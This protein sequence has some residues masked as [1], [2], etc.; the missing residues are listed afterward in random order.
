[1]TTD[2][3]IGRIE[4][5]SSKG[6]LA[7]L[8][9]W[10][11]VLH[12][13]MEV[14]GRPVGSA[15]T[16]RLVNALSAAKLLASGGGNGGV[17]QLTAAVKAAARAEPVDAA[18]L[19]QSWASLS[20]LLADPMISIEETEL[21]DV[22]KA[23]K[24]AKEFERLAE[25]GERAIV[26]E[27]EDAAIRLLY[28]QALIN[29]GKVHAGLEMLRTVFSLKGLRQAEIDEA[30][31][32]MGRG[33]KQIYV[34]NVR[35]AGTSRA[36]RDRFKRELAQSIRHYE[37]AYRPDK[38][39]TNYWHGINLVS[40]M[41]LARRDGHDDLA[42]LDGMNPEAL[43]QRLV[44]ALEPQAEVGEH[45]LLATLGEASIALGDYVKAKEWYSRF[46]HHPDITQF[47][48]ASASRQLEQVWRLSPS[49]GGAGPLFAVLKAAE[50][51]SPNGRFEL[52][53]DG[54]KAIQKFAA[55][56]EAR[57]FRES[58]VAGGKFVKLAELQIVVKRAAAVVAIQGSYGGTIGTGFIVEGRSLDPALGSDWF[59]VTNAHV[60][61]GEKS[62]TTLLPSEARLIL[63]GANQVEL[64]CE[65][66]LLFESPPD[67]Y[68][69]AIVRIT[70]G[71]SGVCEP[72]AVADPNLPIKPAMAQDGSDG[73]PVSVIGYPLGG[74]L[75][76]SRVVGANGWIV[77]RGPRTKTSADPVYMH[78]IAPTEPGNSG[79]PIFETGSWQVIGLHHAGFD[80]YE[81][82]PRLN[83]A[84][85]NSF[86]NEG[87]CIQSIRA[88]LK[89]NSGGGP[90]KRGL[91]SL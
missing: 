3:I 17:Y 80:K 90:R 10:M 47:C 67:A 85:G 75:S 70:G 13:K 34:D 65:G 42:T 81:G 53:A 36:L 29:S 18:G 79:S 40:L 77:D 55:T 1:M 76:L 82:R 84:S 39:G 4:T 30:H 62:R 35:S 50:V 56:S 5:A 88:A 38:P 9:H 52:P 27:P 16:L 49:H 60:L 21:V 41:M 64:T 78:Y 6:D 69:A 66:K 24:S 45:W 63:E 37:Q 28:G 48:A 31:G 7:A 23:L 12:R 32:L 2:E 83:G 26:R 46:G 15:A 25:A 72:L 68:D 73:S 14:E 33:Y 43:A 19:A 8:Q 59:M 58:M 61:S 74:P 57:S 89:G 87:I 91:F 20:R 22:M 54:L 86:A 11:Q 71:P 51:G 44:D